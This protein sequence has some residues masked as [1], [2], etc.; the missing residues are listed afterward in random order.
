MLGE[1]LARVR[2]GLRKGIVISVGFLAAALVLGFLRVYIDFLVD[3][4]FSVIYAYGYA[5]FAGSVVAAAL[6]Y[7]VYS[8]NPRMIRF[9]EGVGPRVREADYVPWGTKK[10]GLLLTL[11]SGLLLTVSRN[12]VVFR[13]LMDDGG[14]VLSLTLD[15]WSSALREY[16][17]VRRRATV[18]TRSGD[19]QLKESLR[20]V[21]ER[22]GGR[23]AMVSV[24]EKPPAGPSVVPL[25]RWNAVAMFSISR[26]LN[27]A[28]SIRAALDDVQRLLEGMRSV[29][30]S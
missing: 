6:G 11:D 18:T 17:G 14:R 25:S 28:D 23:T 21:S 20:R 2:S 30:A 3:P 8:F 27:R 26:W 1:P 13:V 22:L 10:R 5:A 7:Q 9:V 12:F 4:S 16:R 24:F 19:P 15:E 29:P